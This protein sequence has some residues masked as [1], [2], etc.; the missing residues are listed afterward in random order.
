MLKDSFSPT[1]K[2]G[3]AITKMQTN[4]MSG[5]T[6]DEFIQEFK[7][8]KLQ[9]GVTE[10][11]PLIEW[12][13]TALPSTLRDKIVLLETPPTTLD[14]WMTKASALDNNWRKFKAISAR[15]R[16]DSKQKKKGLKFPSRYVLPAYNDPN[17]MD[18]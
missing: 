15:L 16:G 11:R 17:A 14:A 10:D 2:E 7:N 6:A 18:T 9:S 5:K 4:T 3:D 13:M 1:D 12:F 8:W